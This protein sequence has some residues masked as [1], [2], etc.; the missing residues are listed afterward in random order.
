MVKKLLLMALLA[1]GG[2]HAASLT[3]QLD[4]TAITLGEP[5]SVF[6]PTTI[7]PMSFLERMRV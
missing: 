7:Q 5:P 1:N 6:Q 4:K 2:V 3:A